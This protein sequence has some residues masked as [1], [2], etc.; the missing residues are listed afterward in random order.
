[1]QELISEC[2]SKKNVVLRADGN[3]AIGYGHVY[4]VLAIAETLKGYY[5]CTLVTQELPEFLR[6][7]ASRIGLSCIQLQGNHYLSKGD[8]NDLREIEFDM[9]NLL[10]GNEIVVTDGYRF[11]MEYQKNINRLGSKLICIDDLAGFKFY[12]DVVINHAPG[13]DESIY[14]LSDKTR[15]LTGLDYLMIRK[16]FLELPLNKSARFKPRCV[17]CMGGADY[18]N[19]TENILEEVAEADLDISFEVIYSHSY[20]RSSI[21][22][23]FD[24]QAIYGDRISLRSNLNSSE[25][26]SIFDSCTHALISASTI[27]LEC[28]ARKIMPLVGFYT[29]NQCLL[30]QGLIGTDLAIGAG[31]LRKRDNFK[32][33]ATEYLSMDRPLEISLKNNIRNIFDEFDITTRF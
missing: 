26:I 31:D 22:K 24:L 9:T 13:I 8:I 12:A 2:K 23:L 19:L 4:R 15:L 11:G 16:D 28:I 17:I 10:T 5:N 33:I 20:K 32:T 18:Y 3:S 27:S 14:N 21:E 1:M 6:N 30:Y 7:E 29:A 25:I